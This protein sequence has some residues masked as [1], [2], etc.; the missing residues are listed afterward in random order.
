MAILAGYWDS[1]CQG[2][3]EWETHAAD[4]VSIIPYRYISMV[5]TIT[6][7]LKPGLGG[8]GEEELIAQTA[9]S[10]MLASSASGSRP[11]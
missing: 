5:Q 1:G 10:T 2:G 4:Q 8:S 7:E 9:S 11:R 3:T 6:A